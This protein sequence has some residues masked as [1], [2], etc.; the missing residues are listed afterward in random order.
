[1]K[2]FKAK[3]FIVISRLTCNRVSKGTDSLL[4][5]RWKSR[6]R[7]RDVSGRYF[8][9][10]NYLLTYFPTYCLNFK[11]PRNGI[12]V[13]STDYCSPDV[14]ARANFVISKYRKRRILY[15]SST[16]LDRAWWLSPKC[17]IRSE[18]WK[19][20][21]ITVREAV[22]FLY[23]WDVCQYEEVNGILIRLIRINR[24]TITSFHLYLCLPI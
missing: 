17:H 8:L 9:Q 14:H 19:L 11:L 23:N 3:Y 4:K 7:I 13:L 16:P 1:M 15:V 2:Q 21:C 5:R 20:F 12:M 10:M 18:I 6:E 22:W 24:P